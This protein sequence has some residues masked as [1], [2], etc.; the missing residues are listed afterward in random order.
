MKNDATN[1][2]TSCTRTP[3][4]REQHSQL[5]LCTQAQRRKKQHHDH[6]HTYKANKRRGNNTMISA[7]HKGEKKKKKQA[8]KLWG[9]TKVWLL[10]ELKRHL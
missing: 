1:Y 8:E 5:V 2:I 3:R 10:I 4:R 7:K 9:L 6:C